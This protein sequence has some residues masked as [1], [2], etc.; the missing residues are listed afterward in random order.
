MPGGPRVQDM[1]EVNQT[2]SSVTPRSRASLVATEQSLCL[3]AVV[4]ATYRLDQY[5]KDKPV[6]PGRVKGPLNDGPGS[7]SID[8]GPPGSDRERPL[9]SLT[10]NR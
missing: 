9:S 8:T 5:E 10:P 2:G 7:A 4:E 3:F 1:R 6:V